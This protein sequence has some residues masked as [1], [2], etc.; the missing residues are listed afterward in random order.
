MKTRILLY[1]FVSIRGASVAFTQSVG[2]PIPDLPIVTPVAP[3]RAGI[4]ALLL[5]SDVGNGVAL[6]AP[7]SRVRV[8]LYEEVRLLV[9]EGWSHPI[10]WTKDDQP[11]AGATGRAYIIP[12]ATPADS[13]RYNITGAPFPF[14]ATG[15]AL[16]VVRQGSIGNFSARL[17]LAPGGT[18]QI[19]GFVVTGKTPKTLLVRAVGPSL[20][21]FGIERFATQPRARLYDAEG[22]EINLGRAAV[23]IDWA[24]VFAGAGAFPLLPN[25]SDWREYYT[26]NPGAYTI[27]VT[28]ES[29]QGGAVLV[30]AYELAF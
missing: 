18:P 4:T 2:I 1:F 25:T 24:A 22:K 23:V 10:Q 7:G 5:G 29:R 11:I 9:P 30:E 3:V 28:D 13:G 21:S 8:P 19:V 27:H 12:L 16:D 20:T 15:V 14:I 6:P 26:L 17:D